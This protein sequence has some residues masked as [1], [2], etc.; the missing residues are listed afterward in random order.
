L[1][2]F[3]LLIALVF[4]LRR[5]LEQLLVDRGV[6]SVE[7]VRSVL[8]ERG[9]NPAAAASAARALAA[10]AADR[11]A[12]FAAV[13]AALARP[14]R[15]V[16]GKAL[17]PAAAAGDVNPSLFAQDEERALHAALLAAETSLGIVAHGASDAASAD[18]AASIEVAAL[19]AAAEPLAAPVDA[20]FTSVFV[21]AEDEALRANRLALAARLARLPKGVVDLTQLPGF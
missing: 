7:Q 10:E 15:L 16:R 1:V 6:A 2:L 12:R 19:F 9:H 11:P 5:R 21:M 4:S 8:A 3:C 18:A 14:T 20:F 17:P 13:L